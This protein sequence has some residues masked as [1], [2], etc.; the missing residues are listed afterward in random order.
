MTDGGI[1]GEQQKTGNVARSFVLCKDIEPV[2][3]RDS[4]STDCG[5]G[6]EESRK[7]RTRRVKGVV[8]P[9]DELLTCYNC[10]EVGHV[11]CNC[12]KPRRKKSN[13]KLV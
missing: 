2:G 6:A 3:K 11:S 12:P 5:G 1:K 10:D 8:L 7:T 9:G 4:S 13:G